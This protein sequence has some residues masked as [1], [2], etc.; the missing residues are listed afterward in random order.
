[1]IRFGV[2]RCKILQKSKKINN[3]SYFSMLSLKE[4][5]KFHMKVGK[6]NKHKNETCVK[7][8]SLTCVRL[9]GL[10][11]SA[12]WAAVCLRSGSNETLLKV[13]GELRREDDC[14]CWRLVGHRARL[15]TEGQ[16]H[17]RLG[18]TS[19]LSDVRVG[20]CVCESGCGLA[21]RRFEG[22]SYINVATCW[23]GVGYH[24][25]FGFFVLF[26]GWLRISYKQVNKEPKYMHI[27]EKMEEGEEEE[28][29]FGTL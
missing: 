23:A 17:H 28:G 19:D 27:E 1:M 2:Q 6:R 12:W 11:I 15:G 21:W 9:R 29:D 22:R 20:E 5:N 26:C 7:T 13:S 10:R 14:C 3:C 25:C 18:S 16:L 8:E 24:L 4:L